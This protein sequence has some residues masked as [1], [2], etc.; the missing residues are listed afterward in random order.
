[1]VAYGG[2][3][4]VTWA[5]LQMGRTRT[6][7]VVE[8]RSAAPSAVDRP[9]LTQGA[10]VRPGG[11]VVEAAFAQ[12]LGLHVGDRLSLGGSSFEVVGIAVTAAFPSYPVAGALGASWWGASVPT[13]SVSSG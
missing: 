11:V 1:M 10:W 12:A 6:T 5:L 3:F 9:K 2:P 4:P 8:G 13:T 7:A